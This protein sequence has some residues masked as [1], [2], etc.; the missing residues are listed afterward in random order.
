MN[1]EKA[2]MN[3]SRVVETLNRLLTRNQPDA[4]NSSWIREHALNVIVSFGRISTENLG[5]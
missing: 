4:F 2:S 1:K 5:E 3:F